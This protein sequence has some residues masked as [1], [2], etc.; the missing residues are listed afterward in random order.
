MIRLK[1]DGADEYIRLHAQVWPDVISM[2][3]ASNIR[4]Y[5]IYLKNTYLFTY[6]EY[7]G[8]DNDSDITRMA[9]HPETQQF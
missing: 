5:S 3:S 7:T 9:S 2:I 4:N 6:F 1:P 8:D